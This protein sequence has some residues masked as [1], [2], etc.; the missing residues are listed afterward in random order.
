[1][2]LI[3]RRIRALPMAIHTGSTGSPLIDSS[4]PGLAVT[5][6]GPPG[7]SAE[8]LNCAGAGDSEQPGHEATEE[9][10]DPAPDR[11]PGHYR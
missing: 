5:C 4:H 2:A 11:V 1:M 3:R 8:N 9:P 7:L 6:G 10:A